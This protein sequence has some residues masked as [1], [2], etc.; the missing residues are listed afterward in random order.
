LFAFS[1]A[2]GPS[3]LGLSPGQPVVSVGLGRA[4]AVEIK[5]AE[6]EARAAAPSEQ[7]GVR[8]VKSLQVAVHSGSSK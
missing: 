1:E 3:T 7:Q 6:V 2:Q 5:T 8:A 4:S